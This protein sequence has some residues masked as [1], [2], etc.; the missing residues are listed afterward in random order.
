MEKTPT[1][2]VDP[3]WEDRAII[4]P[5]RF[6][7]LMYIKF[8]MY[9]GFSRRAAF[10]F[11]RIYHARLT[12]AATDN[13][14]RRPTLQKTQTERAFDM[15][16]IFTTQIPNIYM[17]TNGSAKVSDKVAA[18]MLPY[19]MDAF[20]NPSS[21]H[22]ASDKAKACI[23]RAR[24]SVAE[25]IGA[26][27][28]EIVFTSG[29]TEANNFALKGI[30]NMVGR[31]GNHF[32]TS[33]VE[34]ESIMRPLRFLK[35]QGAKVTVLPVDRYG[36]VDPEA[37]R[38][39][40]TRQ[41]V[42]ISIMQANNETGTVQPIRDIATVAAEAGVEI[43]TDGA[44]SVGKIRVDV[45]DLGVDM[46]SLAAHKFGGPNGI[47]ALYI[48]KGLRLAPLLHGAAHEGGR[49]A[50]T[51]SALLAA[52]IGAAAELARRKNPDKVRMLRDY[53][54]K[55]LTTTFGPRVVLNGHPVRRVPNTLSV[56][57]PGHIG[58]E[59]LAKMPHVAATTGS[60][61]HAGC[62][63]MSSVLIAMGA[64]LEVGMGTIRFSLSD[65]NTTEEVDRVVAALK[66][67]L[68]RRP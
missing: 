56:S 62:V 38:A 23:A 11:S 34:H 13:L 66:E 68:I 57:F 12:L 37:V 60:A 27:P 31:T 45:R 19:L 35:T 29:G 46:L 8:G 24:Q 6:L 52:G 3:L 42:L 14:S 17:D 67:A 55:Q 10:K 32:I 47:G 44:Q 22:W 16:A 33:A 58:A 61:C 49:R 51:E 28:E 65:D 21:G 20:G 54:W 7:S 30:W 41:T 1:K 63:T 39:A 5:G 2:N 40:I 36:R 26:K 48:R 64:T 53:F 4:R 43:H 9:F 25:L 59:L 18:A 50:G 15:N